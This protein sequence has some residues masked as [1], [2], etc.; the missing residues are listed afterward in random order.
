M[1]NKVLSFLSIRGSFNIQ[2]DKLN[3]QLRAHPPSRVRRKVYEFS[4]KM[5]DVLHFQLVSAKSSWLNVFNELI[6]NENDIAL[7][8]FPSVEGRCVS[9]IH[10]PIENKQPFVSFLGINI[11]CLCLADVRSIS[12]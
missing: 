5:P 12:L 7:Y 6:P 4:M 8:F 2:E 11:L 10:G 9:T 1:H 3:P